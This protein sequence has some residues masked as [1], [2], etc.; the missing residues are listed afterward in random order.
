MLNTNGRRIARDDRFLKFLAD[1]RGR[2]EVYLQ[3][4][5]LRPETHLA[6]RGEVLTEEKPLALCRL[7]EAGIYTTLVMTV[8]RGVNEDEVG[9]VIQT[10]LKTPKCAGVAIQPM[11]MSRTVLNVTGDMTIATCVA[12]MEERSTAIP[13]AVAG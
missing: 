8:C 2:I 7:N 13:E 1:H 5:G 3:F 6:L 12:A 11:D 4:D 9:T 10:G